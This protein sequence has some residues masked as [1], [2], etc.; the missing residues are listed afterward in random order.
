MF[1]APEL[2]KFLAVAVSIAWFLGHGAGVASAQERKLELVMFEAAYCEWCDLWNEEI[3]VVYHKTDEG[4][5]APLR[6]VDLHG[7]RPSDLT[8]VKRLHYTPTFVLMSDGEEVG[9][10]LGYPGEHFF[11]PMLQKLLDRDEEING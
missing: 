11:W 2:R 4:A 5:S 3:G 8:Q 1:L 6:R 9:R 7:E 10:I